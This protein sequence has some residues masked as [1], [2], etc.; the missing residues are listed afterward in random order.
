MQTNDTSCECRYVCM[1]VCFVFNKKVL[2]HSYNELPTLL[3][4]NDGE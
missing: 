4:C 1:Y 3:K 2:E